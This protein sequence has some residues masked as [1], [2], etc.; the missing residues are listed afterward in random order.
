MNAPLR[1][2]QSRLSAE[3][4]DTNNWSR[5]VAHAFSR[6]APHYRR[7]ARA[8][9]VMAESLWPHLPNTARRIVDIGCGPGDLTCA[10]A[11]H[12]PEAQLLGV[13]LSAAMLDAARQLSQQPRLT[14]LCADATQLPL[15]NASQDLVVSNL[16]IQWCPDLTATLRELRRV[17]RPGGRAV[18]NTLAPGTLS[19][20]EHVW[21]RPGTPS[22]LLQFRDAAQHRLAAQLSGWSDIAIEEFQQRFYYPDLKAVMN[23]IKGVGAQ[24]SGSSTQRTR[25]DIQRARHRYET[26]R[27]SEGLPVS[28]Q[29]LTLVL[30]A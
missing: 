20:I 3:G 25:S 2:D 21:R 19:E 18:I 26:L 16:A 5:R 29:R 23:S 28:Y 30:D 22:G 10:L 11:D 14:W 6:A 15:A 17:M 8:Q 4:E 1:V 12:F 24:L 27:E 13:D 9:A 7:H